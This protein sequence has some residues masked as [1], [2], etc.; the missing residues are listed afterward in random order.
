MPDEAPIHSFDTQGGALLVFENKVRISR[1]GCL[2]FMRHGAKGDKDIPI[3]SITAMQLKEPGLTGS[4]YLQFNLSGGS[5]STGGVLDATEDE[6]TVMLQNQEQYRKAKEAKQTIEE[7]MY[8]DKSTEANDGGSS[9]SSAEE[10]EKYH[11]LLEKG[12]I[13]EEEYEQKKKEVLGG[14]EGT[15]SESSL[16]DEESQTGIPEE[17]RDT[18][19]AETSDKE[20]LSATGSE[21]EPKGRT[22]Y[23]RTWVVVL[24]SFLVWPV[25][26][27]ALYKNNRMSTAGKFG[28]GVLC[29]LMA[30]ASIGAGADEESSSTESSGTESPNISYADSVKNETAYISKTFSSNPRNYGSDG[31]G[32]YAVQSE[33]NSI[34]REIYDTASKIKEENLNIDKIKIKF[35]Q[36]QCKDY[37][38]N[39]SEDVP[40]GSFT[41]ENFES[42]L[43]SDGATTYSQSTAWKFKAVRIIKE[44]YSE[45][46]GSF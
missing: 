36:G 6:N 32:G 7:L 28:T 1:S 3:S 34:G 43:N 5:T 23:N 22:W 19:R 2:S 33:V 13:T 29:A 25:G 4:G 31:F 41:F 39:V 26:A 44:G 10:L 38:G 14:G 45:C 9:L 8:E 30:L 12:A 20:P 35:K 15:S 27:Y 16:E 40:S 18:G 11:D 24:L 37:N 17:T 46:S 42:V 21:E